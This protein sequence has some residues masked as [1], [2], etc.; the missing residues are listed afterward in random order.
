VGCLA[1]R[2]RKKHDLE[3]IWGWSVQPGHSAVRRQSVTHMQ[4]TAGGLGS[5]TCGGCASFRCSLS[6]KI[7]APLDRHGVPT[8]GRRVAGKGSPLLSRAAERRIRPG[9]AFRCEQQMLAIARA[10]M[11]SPSH[12]PGRTDR[13]TYA[14]MDHS[15]TDIVYCT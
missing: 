1:Q 14:R 7:S 11:L 10:M 15:Q 8:P 4:S 9:H 12:P 2:S 13:G 5:P 3:G 6:L